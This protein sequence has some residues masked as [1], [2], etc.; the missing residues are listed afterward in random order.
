MKDVTASTDILRQLCDL[1][2]RLA[3]DDFGTGYSSLARLKLFP[4]AQLKIDRSF[5]EGL[6]DNE[7]DLAIVTAVITMG[8]SLGF[9]VLAEGIEPEAQLDALKSLGCDLG[10]G[11]FFSM[12][13]RC[14]VHACW[15]CEHDRRTTASSATESASMRLVVG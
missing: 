10:Q 8:H 13:C 3:I 1:G 7:D 15:T 12:R 14:R 9:S 4:I 2:V 6:P 5:V 11:F